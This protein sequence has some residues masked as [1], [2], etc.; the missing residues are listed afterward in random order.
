MKYVKV[1]EFF[2][3]FRCSI[4]DWLQQDLLLPT[5]ARLRLSYAFSEVGTHELAEVDIV[6]SGKR[7]R[8][9]ETF[10]LSRTC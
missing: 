1:S 10:H 9:T 7:G 5:V 4:V 6:V 8:C 3:G 2:H